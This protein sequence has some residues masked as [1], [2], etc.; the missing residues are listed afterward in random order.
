MLSKARCRTRGAGCTAGACRLT[1]LLVCARVVQE[2][3]LWHAANA[4]V[5]DLV[6]QCL[7]RDP[8]RRITAAAALGHPWLTA[9]MRQ[10]REVAPNTC[11]ASAKR[12]RLQKAAAQGH[13]ED[14]MKLMSKARRQRCTP[15]ARG[16]ARCFCAPSLP[17]FLFPLLLG[18]LQA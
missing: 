4:N 5:R 8:V 18:G 15:C 10:S 3:E 11:C 9:D 2:D 13:V 16:H 14:F 12:A 1:W 17:C 7:E 6:L